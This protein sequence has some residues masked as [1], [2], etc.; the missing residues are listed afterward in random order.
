MYLVGEVVGALV[1]GR[2]S[3]ALGRRKLFMVTLG[4]YLFGSGLT[5]ATAGAGPGW[6][7]FLYL[8]RFI[9]GAGIGGEYAAINSAIDEMIP[10]RYRGRVDIG[11]NGT[12]WAGA[13]IGTLVSLAFLNWI[14]RCWAGGW[15][16]WPARRWQWSSCMSGEHCRKARAGLLTHGHAAEAEQG[17]A[18]IEATVEQDLGRPLPPVD[19]SQAIESPPGQDHR[20]PHPARAGVHRLL[21]AGGAGRHPV[22]H[23]VVPVQRDL[24]HLRAGA[25]Q[26]LRGRRH[27]APVY[28]IAFAA[29][30]LAGPLVLGRLYDTIGR[31]PR[32]MI[33]AHLPGLGRACSMSGYLFN[34]GGANRTHPDHR[35]VHHLLLRVGRGELRLPHRQRDLPAGNP[36]EGDR[37]VLRDRPMF[38]A[39]GPIITARSSA[40]APEPLAAVPGRRRCAW[41]RRRSADASARSS[42]SMP[43]QVAGR[44]R[45]PTGSRRRPPPTSESERRGQ[46]GPTRPDS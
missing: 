38:G 15:P 10:A 21:A 28:L 39:V 13:I 44:H 20:L 9:A 14:G 8:T 27:E 30:N 40:T 11:V 46:P 35:L 32:K 36:R 17:I 3:D 24:F 45:H 43:R 18:G 4:V 7:A 41:Q 37:G 34:A 1:F 42:R 12:Y 26:V 5:A 23:P 6:V 31:K 2:L 29:G 25:H 22:D 33:T 19:S 16:S